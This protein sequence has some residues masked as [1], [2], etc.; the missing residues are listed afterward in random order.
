MANKLIKRKLSDS[1]ANIG[2]GSMV[3][4]E[5]SGKSGFESREPLKINFQNLN[6]NKKK[7]EIVSI[8]IESLEQE[9]QR[10]MNVPRTTGLRVVKN[11]YI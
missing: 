7:R 3:F 9:N 10:R 6:S 4:E 2:S 8:S 1:G 11:R 5:G